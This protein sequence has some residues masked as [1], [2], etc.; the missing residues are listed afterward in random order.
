MSKSYFYGLLQFAEME[1]G[2]NSD[3][4]H[5]S[6]RN[7]LWRSQFYYRTSRLLEKKIKQPS[8]RD[9]MLNRLVEEF[10]DK[11]IREYQGNYKIAL[12]HHLYRLRAQE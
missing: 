2:L 9:N 1:E 5:K 11:G 3:A 10:I 7:A 12:H 8:E 6:I 4:A